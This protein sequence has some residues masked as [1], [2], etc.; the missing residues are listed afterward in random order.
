MPSWDSPC[1]PTA[2]RAV[3]TAPSQ[4]G[5]GGR[6]PPGTHL[7]VPTSWHPAPRAQLLVPTSPFSR[8]PPSRGRIPNDMRTLTWQHTFP[9]HPAQACPPLIEPQLTPGA[10]KTCDMSGGVNPSLGPPC[11]PQ[12]RWVL[13]RGQ[14]CPPGEGGEERGSLKVGRAVCGQTFRSTGREPAGRGWNQMSPLRPGPALPWH[15][16]AFR[17]LSAGA[18]SSALLPRWLQTRV[19]SEPPPTASSHGTQA[20]LSPGRKRKSLPDNFLGRNL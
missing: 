2:P 18:A 7:P 17:M 14:A 10:M 15:H 9:L 3:L 20:C 6:L 13:G 16:G 19:P 5:Y 8:C 11:G 12:G 1:K 4:R